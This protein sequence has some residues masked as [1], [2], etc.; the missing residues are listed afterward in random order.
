MEN[1]EMSASNENLNNKNNKKKIFIIVSIIAFILL[2]G[3]IGL[4]INN[5]KEKPISNT[6]HFYGQPSSLEDIDTIYIVYNNGKDH[7][8]VSGGRYKDNKIYYYGYGE[9]GNINGEYV[10][11]ID[12]SNIIKYI[13]EKNLKYLKEYEHVDNEKWSLEIS[14][15]GKNCLIS[16]KKEEPKWF[17]DLLKKLNVDK[18]GYLSNSN[19]NNRS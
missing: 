13:Y 1:K 19:S 4:L 5:K 14:S 11:N 7:V 9:D 18:N 3:C 17:K 10:E 12:T 15:P 8:T 16:S 2:I 6:G